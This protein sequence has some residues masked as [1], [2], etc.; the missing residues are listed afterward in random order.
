MVI[1]NDEI[2]KMLCTLSFR[3]I[4]TNLDEKEKSLFLMRRKTIGYPIFA[5]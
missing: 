1:R 3:N 5:I 2:S 4:L